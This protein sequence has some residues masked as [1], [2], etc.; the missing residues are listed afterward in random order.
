M[1]INRNELKT[2]IREVD[3]RIKQ[4]GESNIIDKLYWL[5]VILV[6]ITTFT[7]GGKSTVVMDIINQFWLLFFFGGLYFIIFFVGKNKF[8]KIVNNIEKE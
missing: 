4:V 1:K 7:V 6:A 5:F 2:S 3:T 8:N